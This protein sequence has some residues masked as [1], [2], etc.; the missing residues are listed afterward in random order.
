MWREKK[1][2][3][4]PSISKWFGNSHSSPDP[5]SHAT[6]S[7]TAER[8]KL[9]AR[10]RRELYPAQ[11]MTEFAS[12]LRLFLEFDVQSYL[13][14]GCRSGGTFNVVMRV[15][16]PGS[17]GVAVDLPDGN[18]GKPNSLNSLQRVVQELNHDGID[19]KLLLGDSQSEEMIQKISELGPFDAVLIDGD[20]QYDGVKTD[21]ENYGKIA[22]LV[23]FHDVIGNG[24]FH[25]SSG[26]PVEVPRLW[27][28]I[29]ADGFETREF[30]RDGSNMGIGVVIS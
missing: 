16:P 22:R 26:L 7:S 27:R 2:T 10:I 6:P 12:L 5:V 9:Q 8:S 29:I 13:E 4:L 28:E 15:L 19:S 1:L 21:W 23:A 11:D 25:A 17:T 20:H 18:W 3:K 30:I 14:I 24:V